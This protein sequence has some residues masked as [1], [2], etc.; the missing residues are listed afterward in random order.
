[1][2]VNSTQSMETSM[3]SLETFTWNGY[4]HN[5]VKGD[6]GDD[7]GDIHLEWMQTLHSPGRLL[8]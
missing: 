4:T 2:D 3:M 8:G 5:I 6:V 1:M 7:A